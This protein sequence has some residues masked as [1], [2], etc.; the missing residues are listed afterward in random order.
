MPRKS[1]ADK[2]R[3]AMVAAITP[4]AALPEFEKFIETVREMKDYTVQYWVHTDTVKS[5]RESLLAKGEIRAYLWLIETQK[6]QKELLEAQQRQMAE[7][8]Q[9]A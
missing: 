3:D 4:L 9:Q 1:A 5:E 2:Q 7:Q 8:A 6:A